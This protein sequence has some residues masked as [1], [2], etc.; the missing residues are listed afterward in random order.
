MPSRSVSR[1]RKRRRSSSRGSGMYAMATSSRSVSRGTA[2]G[3]RRARMRGSRVRS[4]NTHA[5]TRYGAAGTLLCSGL[6][7][8][9]DFQFTFQNILGYTEFTPLCDRYMITKVVLT[10]QLVT[11]PDSSNS[12]NAAA[13]TQPTNWFP[14][15][16]YIRDYDGGTA[17][18]IDT[19][20]ERVGV[21][22]KILQPNKIFKVVIKPRVLVQTYR[23][24]T[25][26][27][28]A[29]K[30]LFLDIS[31]VDIPHY[32]LKT[33]IDTNNNDPIDAYPFV[34]RFE[35]K[36]YFTIKDIR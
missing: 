7:A 25:T 23:T 10:F 8:S 15:M 30:R 14:K 20:K 36:F 3:M 17:E 1:G 6:Q 31:A 13:V 18:T 19:I 34:V 9:N 21:K 16:W 12:L 28:Y 2:S 11:N 33:V 35:Q 27:G 24:S 26:T 32:G 22:C 5:F 4:L 29:P